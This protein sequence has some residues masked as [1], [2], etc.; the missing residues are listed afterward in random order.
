MWKTYVIFL[1]CGILSKAMSRSQGK[2]MY[3]FHF[4]SFLFYFNFCFIL[5]FSLVLRSSKWNYFKLQCMYNFLVAFFS[6]FNLMHFISIFCWNF[7]NDAITDG[8][9]FLLVFL[10]YFSL[11]VSVSVSQSLLSLSVY[12]YIYL[13]I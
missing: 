3:L 10:W 11:C 6:I 4:V 9:T 2:S 7:W 5:F 1:D 13:N 8:L 12:I